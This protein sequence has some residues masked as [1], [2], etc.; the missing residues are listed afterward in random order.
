MSFLL[1]DDQVAQYHRD[2]FLVL[3]ALFSTSEI[4]KLYRV[5]LADEVIRKHSYELKDQAGKNTRLALWFTPG[6]DIY[7]MLSRT[8]RI[9]RQV[10][11]LLDGYSP[12]CHFHSKLMQKE[13]RSGGSWEWHQDFGYW[14]KN[15]FLFPD[16][17]LSVMVAISDAHKDNGCLQVIKGSHK[18]GRIDHGLAGEQVTAF[19]HYVDLSLKSM[20]LVYVELKAGDTLFF[21][22]NTLHR[23]EANLSDHA[24]WSMISCYNRQSNKPYNESSVS[25]I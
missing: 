14:H 18:M 1:T 21:H 25:C 20:E 7:G 3:P 23:S 17:M 8:E 4:D 10:E 9:V 11:L 2:G 5:A 6:N 22:S 15:E 13:P 16:Q 19:Q 24:R 12:V